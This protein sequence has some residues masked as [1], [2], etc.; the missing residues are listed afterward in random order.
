MTTK[1]QTP[2]LPFNEDITGR[3]VPQTQPVGEPQPFHDYDPNARYADRQRELGT[4]GGIADAASGDLGKTTEVVNTAANVARRRL[5]ERPGIASGRPR[6][7]DSLPT[8]E[9]I[10]RGMTEDEIR[11]QDEVNKLGARAVRELLNKQKRF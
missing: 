6:W 10:K 1:V 4:G 3:E 9:Q 5:S 2:Q 11:R 7:E 8:T